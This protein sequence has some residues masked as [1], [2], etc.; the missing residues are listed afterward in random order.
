MKICK[1]SSA[2][3]A[4]EL[5]GDAKTTVVVEHAI[6][7]CMAEWRH[8]AEALQDRFRVLLYDRAGYGKSSVSLLERTPDNIANELNE[9]LDS[10]N[11]EDEF[12]LI[13]HS[14]GG[15]YASHFALKYPYRV[16]ALV[17]LDPATPY[18]G[19]F[20][21]LLSE[22][23][24][25]NSGV[26]KSGSFKTARVL[27][28][29]KLG[30]FFRPLL[31][32]SPPFYYY[33]FPKGDRKDLLSSLTKSKTYKTALAEY[34]FTHQLDTV[35]TLAAGIEHT[36]LQNILLV[37]LTH[38]SSFYTKELVQ[39]GYMEGGAAEKVENVWQELMKRFLSLSN[40]SSFLTA[41]NS[42]HY[43]HLTDTDLLI[44]TLISLT[45]I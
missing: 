18:D 20:K 23:E 45:E 41:E 2:E 13:G 35:K 39:F 29:L 11:I 19:E 14:Q 4:Y 10:L 1:I 43:I 9:L 34:R 25:K 8:I 26:D 42:G 16:K 21:T 33:K 27:T 31:K 40:L 24:Y 38:S 36:K 7:S 5:Y 28:A 30:F 22:E 32:K 17:L 3:I 44:Q 37:L 6:A 15:F 12:I